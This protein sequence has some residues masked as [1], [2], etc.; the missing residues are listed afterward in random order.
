MVVRVG[1]CGAALVPN[2]P[3]VLWLAEAGVKPDSLCITCTRS[4]RIHDGYFVLSVTGPFHTGMPERL[5]RSCSHISQGFFFFPF[6]A[7]V[8]PVLLATSAPIHQFCLSDSRAVSCG[9]GQ[10]RL[11]FFFF[12]FLAITVNTPSFAEV[13]GCPPT[14][15]CQKTIPDMLP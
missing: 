5:N 2:R 12:L 1:I 6:S 4:Y 9:L 15:L 3:G 8:G 13:P 11:F 14:L 10:E 7:S